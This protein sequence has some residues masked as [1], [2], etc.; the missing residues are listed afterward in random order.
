MEKRL[1]VWKRELLRARGEK[2]P[3]AQVR[4]SVPELRHLLAALQ[5]RGWRGLEHLPHWS[6]WRRR[7]Q[8][9]TMCCPYRKRGS[10]LPTTYLQL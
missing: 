1:S 3:D 9:H 6:Q 10:S 5:W 8:F 4:L 2:T 7:H